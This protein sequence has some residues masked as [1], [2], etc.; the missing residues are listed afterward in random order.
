MD[1]STLV[2]VRGG[3]AAMLVYQ[4]GAPR[5]RLHTKLYKIHNF[6]ITATLAKLGV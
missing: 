5:W 2:H 6:S 4:S 3:V 1:K